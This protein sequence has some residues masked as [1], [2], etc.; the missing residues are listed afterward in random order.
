MPFGKSFAPGADIPMNG[1]GGPN[2]SRPRG[3]SPQQA[4]KILS[5]RVPESLPSNAPVNR[6]LL[7]SPGGAAPV[8]GGLQSL[9][10]QLIQSFKPAAGAPGG[11]PGQTTRMPVPGL[12]P[13]MGGGAAPPQ[14]TPR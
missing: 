4:V 2:G 9:I 6:S 3:L 13:G 12:Q 1:Q 8:A 11:A 14:Y 10:Q 5:L 7:T